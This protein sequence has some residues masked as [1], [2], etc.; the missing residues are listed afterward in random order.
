MSD[1]KKELIARSKKLIRL[2]KAGDP[3]RNYVE[4]R[5]NLLKEEPDHR[6]VESNKNVPGFR[7]TT[8]KE[9]DEY[10]IFDIEQFIEDITQNNA[11]KHIVGFYEDRVGTYKNIHFHD[12]PSG[13]GSRVSLSTTIDQP[14][15][16]S[17][18]TLPHL[19]H[20]NS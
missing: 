13:Q 14:P 16:S 3:P 10:T 8:I 19:Q 18:L 5:T 4:R 2:I 1:E 11:D 9:Y 6:N 17:S 7:G 12:G 15:L 20:R